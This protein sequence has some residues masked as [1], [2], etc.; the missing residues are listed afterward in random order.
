MVSFSRPDIAAGIF[1]EYLRYDYPISPELRDRVVDGFPFLLSP[2]IQVKGNSNIIIGHQTSQSIPSK[3]VLSS[4]NYFNPFVVV[5]RSGSRAFEVVHEHTAGFALGAKK[6]VVDPVGRVAKSVMYTSKVVLQSVVETPQ[7]LNKLM[8]RDEETIRSLADFG[9]SVITEADQSREWLVSSI[10]FIPSTIVKVA[11]QDPQALQSISEFFTSIVR[12]V[13]FLSYHENVMSPTESPL[14]GEVN[15]LDEQQ[16]QQL[17]ELYF[18]QLFVRPVVSYPYMR[19]SGDD[20]Y[21]LHALDEISPMI[22]NP[23]MDLT[24]L[25]FLSLVHLYLLLIFIVSF[26]GSYS[27]KT[28]L[29][30]SKRYPI[31]RTMSDDDSESE[32]MSQYDRSSS[33]NDDDFIDDDIV[34]P[35]HYFENE[36]Q[37]IA[38]SA[39]RCTEQHN[40]FSRAVRKVLSRRN[41]INKIRTLINENMSSNEIIKKDKSQKESTGSSRRGNKSKAMLRLPKQETNT[42]DLVNDSSGNPLK[43]KSLSYFL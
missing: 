21:I 29:I 16:K 40:I 20:E 26:P 41:Q 34:D 39:S 28:K 10:V 6:I 27:T 12:V 4:N 17:R 38:S 1:Y 33:W 7:T 13:P 30:V 43:K 24:R 22:V 14:E 2:L 31:S 11:R 18:K 9:K 42:P 25:I 15:L 35:V 32:T 23:T 3:K 19:W 5:L 37:T 36:D 8:Q